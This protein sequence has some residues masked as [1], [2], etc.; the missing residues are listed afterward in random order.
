MDIRGWSADRIMQLPDWC[1]GRRWWI[2]RW[3]GNA[4]AAVTYFL[5]DDKLPERFVL[6]DVMLSTNV[7]PTC[8][9]TDLSIRVVP[10]LPTAGTLRD[11]RPLVRGMDYANVFYELKMPA[12]GLTHLGPMRRLCEGAGMF[13]GGAI[14]KVGQEEN[15]EDMVGVLIASVP[16]EVPDWLVSVS[17][18]NLL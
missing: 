18:K 15:T 7:S 8:T 2:G 12:V 3:I 14:K 10:I 17:G 9:R 16:R 13:L 4:S 1:F 5:F 11:Y 6:W